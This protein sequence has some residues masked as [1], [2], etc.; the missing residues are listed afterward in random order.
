MLD[1]YAVM[2][3]DLDEKQRKARML[4]VD[5]AIDAFTRLAKSVQDSQV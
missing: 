1:E 4:V 2:M 3:R 5:S